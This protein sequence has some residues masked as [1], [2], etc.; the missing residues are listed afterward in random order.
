MRSND[1]TRTGGEVLIDQLAVHGA[2]LTFHLITAVPLFAR[3]PRK[4]NHQR[5]KIAPQADRT[6]VS[7]RALLDRFTKFH[8]DSQ[9]VNDTTNP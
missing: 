7:P 4:Q 5:R 9:T 1:G 8:S 6:S 3:G 2:F